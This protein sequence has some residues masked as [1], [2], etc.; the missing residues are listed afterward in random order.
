VLV[1]DD[2]Y[3]IREFFKSLLGESGIS[4]DVADSGERALE[5]VDAAVNEGR[6]YDVAFIDWRMPGLDGIQTAELMKAKYNLNS[7]IVLISIAQINSV[8]PRLKSAGITKFL[9]KP[10]FP[11]S[12]IDILN[13]ITGVPQ[14]TAGSRQI[15][16]FSGCRILI[17]EDVEINAEIVTAILEPTGAEIVIAG[18]GKKAL[19]TFSSDDNFDMILMDIHMPVMDGYAATA[20]IRGLPKIKAKEIPIIAMTANVFKEDVMRCL[21]TGMNDHI[22]KPIDEHFLMTTL[23][24]YLAPKKRAASG[25]EKS[26]VTAAGDITDAAGF[27]PYID[28]V[29]GLARLCGNKK[30]F[31]R[32]LKNFNDNTSLAPLKDALSND[33]T[34]RAKDLT[35]SIK[36][37]SANLSLTSCYQAALNL[38]TQL[39]TNKQYSAALEALDSTLKTTRIYVDK[40]IN[41]LSEN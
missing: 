13:E 19:D 8:E 3:E 1:A 30:L 32:L 31:A 40:L 25:I 21:S 18:N 41:R 4:V 26:T 22:P 17:A 37:T 12:I 28:T 24:K 35:H 7:L 27:L 34:A 2:S 10:L 5:L 14:R 6:N 15:P 39:N 33:D 36:G 16:D 11:S 20:A 23:S 29:G 38:E 9:A